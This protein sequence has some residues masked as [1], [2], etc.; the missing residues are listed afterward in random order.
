M[1]EHKPR[2]NLLLHNRT[3]FIQFTNFRTIDWSTIDWR[4]LP[5]CRR[6]YQAGLSHG[7][8]RSDGI[9]PF[10]QVHPVKENITMFLNKLDHFTIIKWLITKHIFQ[11]KCAAITYLI[12]NK[13]LAIV[14]SSFMTFFI[15][16]K[17]SSKRCRILHTWIPQFWA[18]PTSD[19]ISSPTFK[20]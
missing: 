18:P 19:T 10:S 15:P 2:R 4:S 7:S 6:F 9:S 17:L 14:S 11:S 1:N 20:K 13:Y 12:K 16:S 5:D 8:R 3:I